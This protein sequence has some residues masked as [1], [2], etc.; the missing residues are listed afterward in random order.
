VGQEHRIVIRLFEPTAVA[1]VLGHLVLSIA[2]LTVR[3]G[4]IEE[5]QEPALSLFELL[6]FEIFRVALVLNDTTFLL[7]FILSNVLL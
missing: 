7:F 1:A 6:L 4:P 2:E 3:A 5:G